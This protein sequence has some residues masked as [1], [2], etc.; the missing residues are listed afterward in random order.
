MPVVEVE[1]SKINLLAGE[2]FCTVS[3]VYFDVVTQ[4]I[5]FGACYQ[6][7]SSITV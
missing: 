3:Y 1:Q 6:G 5:T 7:Q 2:V 4:C